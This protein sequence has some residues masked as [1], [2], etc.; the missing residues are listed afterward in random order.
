MAAALLLGAV[1]V[2]CFSPIGDSSSHPPRLV[3]DVRWD[4]KRE[5]SIGELTETMPTVDCDPMAIRFDEN[6]R[7][8]TFDDLEGAGCAEVR[9]SVNFTGDVREAEL[10]FRADRR[11]VAGTPTAGVSFRERLYAYNESMVRIEERVV[12]ATT[13]PAEG[14]RDFAFRFAVPTGATRLAF[15]WFFHDMNGTQGS[16]YGSTIEAP[17]LHLVDQELPAPEETTLH[18]TISNGTRRSVIEANVSLPSTWEADDR[19]SLR[20]TVDEAVSLLQIMTPSGEPLNRTVVDQTQS[21]GKRTMQISNAVVDELGHEYYRFQLQR[22]APSQ[23]EGQA[24]PRATIFWLAYAALVCPVL[25][26]PGAARASWKYRQETQP[27]RPQRSIPLAATGVV[28][29]TYL[30]ILTL[31]ANQRLIEEMGTLP[32]SGS[33]ASVYAMMFLLFVIGI[34]IW[35]LAGRVLLSHVRWELRENRRLVRELERSNE[36]LQQFAYVASHDLREPLRAIAGYNRL[37]ESQG[38]DMTAK[39][40]EYVGQVRESTARMSAMIDALLEYAK[41]QSRREPKDAVNL[42]TVLADSKRALQT[43]IA[44]KEASIIHEPL[45]VVTGDAAQLGSVFQNLLSNAIKFQRPGTKPVVHISTV[46][47]DDA[48]RISIRDNGIG[49]DPQNSERLFVLFGRLHGRASYPGTGIG[50]ALAKRIVERHGGQIGFESKIGEGSVF[51][52][53]L[54]ATDDRPGT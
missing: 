37:L 22:E 48:W 5:I 47:Q 23:T 50:L 25:T 10:R 26:L 3:E 42:E 36:D 12:F 31:A 27:G 33:A 39:S 19:G 15:A 34:A 52:F 13:D 16:R 32:M 24:V 2:V 9:F 14:F 35:L 53:T 44:E 30:V 20:I 41:V 40:R 6:G 21:R 43:A 4:T 28:A 45:P 1:T 7:R 29:A 18:E 11:I 54:P 46:R 17:S 49:I 8:F 51:W 38:K